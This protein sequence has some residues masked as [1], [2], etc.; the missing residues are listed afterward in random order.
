M[1]QAPDYRLYKSEPELTTVKEE[2]DEAN[3]GED[4]DKTENSADGKDAAVSKGLVAAARRK[5]L[6]DQSEN[7]CSRSVCPAAPP[8]PVGVV[9]PRTKSPIGSPESRT[10]ASYVTLRKTRRPESRSAGVSEATVPG[11][12]KEKSSQ[13]DTPQ[14]FSCEA[15]GI[16]V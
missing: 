16:S 2:V 1:Q 7:G 9:P 5:P 6:P 3:N 8:Y 4:R 11:P 10:I 14:T 12:K 15:G 13:C